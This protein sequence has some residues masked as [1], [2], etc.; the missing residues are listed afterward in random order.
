MAPS[1][2]SKAAPTFCSAPFAVKSALTRAVQFVGRSMSASIPIASF[3][4]SPV[5]RQFHECVNT[6][7]VL[8]MA[9]SAN[10][11]EDFRQY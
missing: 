3:F 8:G 2:C 4:P 1:S 11:T 9:T 7:V 10:R 5:H 6:F